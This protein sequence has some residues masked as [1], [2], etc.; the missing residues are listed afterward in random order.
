MTGQVSDLV[1]HATLAGGDLSVI[2][3]GAIRKALEMQD[4]LVTEIVRR[5]SQVLGYACLNVRHLIDPE[6]IVLG[7][8]VIEALAD[9]MMGVIVETAKDYAM[10]GAMKGVEIVASR[11]GDAAGI[12]GGAVLAR[13][14]VK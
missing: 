14:S 7:G 13:R 12:T 3:S 1:V 10:P 9:E 5:A 4:E 2:R 8:G 6:A 11:L